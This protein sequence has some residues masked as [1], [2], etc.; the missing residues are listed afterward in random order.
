ML[1]TLPRTPARSRCALQRHPA[2]RLRPVAP[3]FLRL[4]ARAFQR[5]WVGLRWRRDNTAVDQLLLAEAVLGADEQKAA[6]GVVVRIGACDFA[7]L[8]DGIPHSVRDFAWHHGVALLSLCPS[9]GSRAFGLV[10][11][12]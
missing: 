2:R 11:R 9:F 7:H 6:A 12:W 3:V 8:G 10:F 4:P 5:G 1:A